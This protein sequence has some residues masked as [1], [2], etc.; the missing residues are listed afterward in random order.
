MI[1]LETLQRF[2]ERARRDDLRLPFTGKG[3]TYASDGSI[4]I[5]V[6]GKVR[7][8]D[9]KGCIRKSADR[10][11]SKRGM[12]RCKFPPLDRVHLRHSVTV[13]ELR[14]GGRPIRVDKRYIDLALGLPGRVKF[15]ADPSRDEYGGSPVVFTFTGGKGAVMP[16]ARMEEETRGQWE[17]S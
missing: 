2:C 8:A 1:A 13:V 7:G 17:T 14:C 15:Y 3:R 10:L 16:M 4:L 12:T 11:L 9:G 6:E 5:R